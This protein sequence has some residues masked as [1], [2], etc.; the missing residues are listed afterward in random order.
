MYFTISPLC[1]HLRCLSP[2]TSRPPAH[3]GHPPA[4]LV[5]PATRRP[6][7]R[8]PRR[9]PRRPG[10]PAPARQVRQVVLFARPATTRPTS[11][12]PQERQEGRQI[13]PCIVDHRR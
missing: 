6:P 7:H 3:L 4:S 12:R 2:Q 11:R 13:P 1:R 9:P 5:P 10:V 8:P